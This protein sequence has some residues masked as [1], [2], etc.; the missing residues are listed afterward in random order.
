MTLNSENLQQMAD[1]YAK[2]WS[3][4]SPDAV[5]SHYAP[6]G[7]ISINRGDPIQGRQAIA[8]MAAGFHAEFPDL[9]IHCDGVRTADDHAI[10]LWTLEGHHV[11]TKSHVKVSGWEEWEL[12]DT[13]QVKSSL[14]WFDA[15]EY[16]RQILEGV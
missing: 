6:N 2:A 14:G 13:M 15:A 5:A 1:N 16:E 11:E 9:V 3:S 4:R 8:E 12:D 7:Q 10:F